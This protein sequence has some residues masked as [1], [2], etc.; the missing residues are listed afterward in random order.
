MVQLAEKENKT[1]LIALCE[2]VIQKGE[3]I[4]FQYQ[5]K[6]LAIISIEDFEYFEALEDR[7]LSELADEAL[8]EPGETIPYETFRAYGIRTASNV[9]RNS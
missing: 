5:G 6:G 9:I 7:R 4:T 1:D 2:E 8:K 3:P